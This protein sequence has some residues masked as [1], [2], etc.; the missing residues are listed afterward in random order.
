M[1]DKQ[2]QPALIMVDAPVGPYS[3][4]DEIRQW[5]RELESMPQIPYVPEALEEARG[6]LRTVL[7]SNG[8]G[9]SAR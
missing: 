2:D 9:R 5:I 1:K 3:S 8:Q 4:P 6:W 7:E